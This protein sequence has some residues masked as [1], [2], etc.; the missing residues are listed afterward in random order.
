MGE[1][2]IRQTAWTQL[3]LERMAPGGAL[4]RVLDEIAADMG[5]QE[6]G[7]SD[8]WEGKMVLASV[9]HRCRHAVGGPIGDG[10]S[11]ELS[12]GCQR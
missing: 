7:W 2:E 10:P 5:R 3:D 9:P 8:S 4:A 1:A 6:R 12:R 11:F